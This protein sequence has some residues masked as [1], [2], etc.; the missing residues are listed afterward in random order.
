MHRWHAIRCCVPTTSHCVPTRPV[1]PAGFAVVSKQQCDEW[2]R[3]QRSADGR[4]PWARHAPQSE[5][6]E[7]ADT[8]GSRT[9]P[10]S[11]RQVHRRAGGS[12]AVCGRCVVDGDCE[13][14]G[15]FDEVGSGVSCRLGEPRLGAEEPILV[16]QVVAAPAR[17]NISG[18]SDEPQKWH[19]SDHE[20]H[21]GRHH[22]RRGDAGQQE[23]PS[24]GHLL[25]RPNMVCLRGVLISLRSTPVSVSCHVSLEGVWFL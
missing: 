16:V 14:I 20:G 10:T 24:H 23:C 7:A 4:H 3:S 8:R 6:D 1:P 22:H 19:Q 9:H 5:P 21:C 2:S 12:G 18:D 25:V 17:L 11:M 15:V 13:G